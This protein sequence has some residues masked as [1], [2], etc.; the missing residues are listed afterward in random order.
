M[1]TLSSDNTV[2]WT[3]TD[4]REVDSIGHR[5]KG[6]TEVDTGASRSKTDTKAGGQKWTPVGWTVSDTFI[7]RE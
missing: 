2:G 6:W 7:F 3:E 1:N 5:K 4:T